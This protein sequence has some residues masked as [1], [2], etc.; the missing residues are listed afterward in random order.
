MVECCDLGLVYLS[1]CYLFFFM[2]KILKTHHNLDNLMMTKNN[3]FSNR[4][5]TNH[6]PVNM[7]ASGSG[8]RGNAVVG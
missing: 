8:L 2:K 3:D 6:G 5:S 7:A 1:V 4:L